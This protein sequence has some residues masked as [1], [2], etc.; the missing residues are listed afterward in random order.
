G[1]SGPI[2][3]RAKRLSMLLKFG[4]GCETGLG[5]RL[6]ERGL[7]WLGARLI[8]YALDSAAFT[9]LAD[10][11][12]PQPTIGIDNSSASDIPGFGKRSSRQRPDDAGK[13][14]DHERTSPLGR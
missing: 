5:E 12:D 14:L 2:E 13:E 7:R 3:R 9:E 6:G 8:L 11:Q 10:H 1:P 4:V